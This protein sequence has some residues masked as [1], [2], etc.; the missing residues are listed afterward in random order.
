MIGQKN[1]DKEEKRNKCSSGEYA[2]KNVCVRG[3]QRKGEVGYD[4]LIDR[5]KQTAL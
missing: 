5:Y 1:C 4:N 3:G 2:E